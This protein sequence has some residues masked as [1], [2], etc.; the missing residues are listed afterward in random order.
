VTRIEETFMHDQPTPSH[1]PAAASQPVSGGAYEP[2]EERDE[3]FE[4]P[5]TLPRRPRRRLLTPLPVALLCVLLIACG[6][7]GGVLV[8]KGQGSSGGSGAS[9]GSALASRFAA[10]RSGAAGGSTGSAAS[11]GAAAGT[12]SGASGTPRTGSGSG[13]GAGAT[14]GQVAFVQ[15]STLY[16]TDT[17]GNTVKVKTSPAST[18]TKT[19]SGTVHAIR[20]GEQV[21]ISGASAAN[22]TV[23]A[24]SIR[25]GA[26]GGGGLGGLFGAGGTGSSSR[27]S[28]AS[29]S[30]SSAGPALFGSG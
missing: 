2:P 18:V 14:I 24:E 23:T 1:P 15:G 17:S 25:V 5:E 4:E 27:T 13:A 30:S 12:G 19:V 29:P 22:G 10:L 21:V 28:G 3:W 26:G 6:F 7:I 8:E 9:G 11:G 20:P 16:V